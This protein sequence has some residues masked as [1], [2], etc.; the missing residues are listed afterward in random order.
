VPT[1][2]LPRRGLT[3]AYLISLG[4]EQMYHLHVSPG[5][6]HVWATRGKIT[7]RG[8]SPQGRTLYDFD[9]VLRCARRNDETRQ[10][11]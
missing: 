5:L 6:I 10:Q 11:L 4:L 8:M 9:E 1:A 3:D 7:R 2:P